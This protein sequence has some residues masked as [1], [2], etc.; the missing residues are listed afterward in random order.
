MKVA[1]SWFETRAMEPGI[2]R[3][4]EKYLDP[5]AACNMYLIEGEVFDLLID[6]GCGF[7]SLQR[8]LP[9]LFEKP[10]ILACSH[11]HFDHAGGAGEFSD[12]RIHGAEAPVL[13][14]P[15]R[16][17]STVEG[18]L[19]TDLF[20]ALPYDGFDPDTYCP[21][22]AEPT[23]YLED[24]QVFDLGKRVLEVIHVPGHS[25]GLVAFY[26]RE[27]RILFSTDSLY[28][29]K[30]YDDVYHSDPEEFTR[31]LEVLWTLEVHRVYGG[32]FELFSRKKMDELIEKYLKKEK[33]R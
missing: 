5:A 2:L 32:H 31:S 1:D 18:F 19:S 21:K 14:R 33:D 20:D 30:L 25:P 28:D 10:V 13:R 11:S 23:G 17:A 12:V 9:G 29:G 6:A 24:G 3:I 4:R 22:P 15:D 27:N 16:I 7:V 26:D 8:S